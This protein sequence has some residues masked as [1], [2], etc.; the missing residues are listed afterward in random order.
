MGGQGSPV[1]L[2][3][4]Y[5]VQLGSSVLIVRSFS[6]FLFLRHRINISSVQFNLIIFKSDW[7]P[8]PQDVRPLPASQ[9]GNLHPDP[10]SPTTRV[11]SCP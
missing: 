3:G 6:H 7:A 2:A 1:W 4:G 8:D 9:H 10:F 5:S 11:P